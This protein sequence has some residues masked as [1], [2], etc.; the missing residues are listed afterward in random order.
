MEN[1]LADQIYR[2]LNNHRWTDVPRHFV[3]DVKQEVVV[4][5]WRQ[6]QKNPISNLRGYVRCVI[7]RIVARMMKREKRRQ[8]DIKSL[9]V[10]PPRHLYEDTKSADIVGE[11]RDDADKLRRRILKL[12]SHEQQLLR[13][14]NIERLTCEQVGHAL[15]MSPSAVRKK[16]GR[17]LRSLRV[18]WHQLAS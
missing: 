9:L 3:D 14:Y 1:E 18:Q 8:K 11:D 13:L 4:A 17:L 16:S 5:V 12:S 15:G 6:S 10:A 2:V 7:G